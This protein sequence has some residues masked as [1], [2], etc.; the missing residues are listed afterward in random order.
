MNQLQNSLLLR[1]GGMIVAITM[2]A[3]V[4]MSTSWMIAETTQGNG[5][6]INLAGS[7]RMQS[8]RMASLY[9]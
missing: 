3:L 5:Q 6:A 2:L 8:W 7:L 4:S 1:I 9:Q